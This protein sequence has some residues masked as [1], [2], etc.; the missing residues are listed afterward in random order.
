MSKTETLN[1]IAHYS[2]GSTRN[3][4]TTEKWH[5]FKNGKWTFVD[6]VFDAAWFANEGSI[7]DL[8][9]MVFDAIETR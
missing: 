5:V 9:K 8:K 4:R 6:I 3:G 7:S 2:H 1:A